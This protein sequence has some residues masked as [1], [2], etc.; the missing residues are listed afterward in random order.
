MRR[1]AG[2]VGDLRVLT[3][4]SLSCASRCGVRHMEHSKVWP[5]ASIGKVGHARWRV[6][7]AQANHSHLGV[8]ARRDGWDK[9]GSLLGQE[10][11]SSQ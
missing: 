8:K 1:L 2:G 5:P 6:L 3:V 9:V 10:V 7:F 11:R 4:K